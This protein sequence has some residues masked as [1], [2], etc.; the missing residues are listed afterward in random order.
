[1]HKAVIFDIDGTLT[2]TNYDRTS[3]IKD[4]SDKSD[5]LWDQFYNLAIYEEP[6]VEVIYLLNSL[7]T[8]GFKIILLTN[9]TEMAKNVT[10]E[11]LRKHRIKFDHLHMRDNGDYVTSA[12]GYKKIMFEKY[13]KDKFDV[14]F[15]VDDLYEIAD[16]FLEYGI[17]TILV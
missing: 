11:W 10:V 3:I 1:M 6:K 8:S 16:M 2:H 5:P 4:Y 15:A 13:I 12:S 9:R 17:P 7:R 14:L